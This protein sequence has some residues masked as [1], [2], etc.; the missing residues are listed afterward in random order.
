MS[1]NGDGWVIINTGCGNSDVNQAASDGSIRTFT[2]SIVVERAMHL[3][4]N[5]RRVALSLLGVT[6]RAMDVFM[7]FITLQVQK[8]V[9]R[10]VRSVGHAPRFLDKSP[11]PRATRSP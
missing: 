6:T 8:L 5:D 9:D 11:V 2:S 1:R 7:R 10:R 3:S 4:S